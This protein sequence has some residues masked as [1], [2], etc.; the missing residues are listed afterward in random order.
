MFTKLFCVSALA[1]LSVPALAQVSL[2]NSVSREVVSTTADG[3]SVTKLEPVDHL[4]PGA[5]AVYVMTYRNGG[6]S[7]AS[8]LVIKNH[9][10]D[11]V[12]YLGEA[13]GS[14]APEVSIDGGKA[15][16]ALAS[17]QVSGADGATRPAT[18]SDVT[19]VR[20][21]VAGPVAPGTSG[22]VSYRARVR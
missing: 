14:P 16:A 7:P 4:E 8:G 6:A 12:A 15:F 3:V 19:D 17:L 11:S 2:E 1:V 10:P 5:V 21:I 18:A 22:S 9:V 13:A 20:W